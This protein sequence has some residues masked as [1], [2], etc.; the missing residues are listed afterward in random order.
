M[1]RGSVATLGIR[2]D[3]G[4]LAVVVLRHADERGGHDE[5]WT[6]RHDPVLLDGFM[7]EFE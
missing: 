2:S 4:R 3:D 6:Q 5:A 7:R 1:A